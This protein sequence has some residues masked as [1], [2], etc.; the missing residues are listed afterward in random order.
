MVAIALNLK[1]GFFEIL[2]YNKY[3]L[4]FNKYFCYCYRFVP[5]SLR[6]LIMTN[7]M[8]QAET[9]VKKISKF[10]NL[11]YPEETVENLKLKSKVQLEQPSK[12]YTFM[13]LLRTPQIRKRSF[14][15]FY[16]W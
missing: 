13:D 14:V 9:L 10:N 5:E 2:K 6:W 16:L 11:P 8:E 15:L 1:Q 12:E 4:I 3:F 7:K